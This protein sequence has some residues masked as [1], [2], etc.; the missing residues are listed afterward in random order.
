MTLHKTNGHLLAQKR[1]EKN[2][3]QKEIAQKMGLR[4]SQYISNIE[5]GLTAPSVN[6]LKVL[7]QEFDFDRNE[8]ADQLAQNYFEDLLEKLS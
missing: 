8:L 4:S 7:V 6:Y 3:S 5:R 2:I 1:I